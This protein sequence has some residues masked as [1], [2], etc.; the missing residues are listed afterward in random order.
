MNFIFLMDPLATVNFEKD[1]SFVFMLESYRR[2]HRVYHLAD[3]DIL[4]DRNRLSFHVTPVEPQNVREKPFI[5]HKRMTIAAETVDA[6]FVRSD[7]PFDEQYLM[8]TWLLDLLPKKVPVI[9]S[10][11]GLRTVNEKI[12]MMQFRSFIPPTFIGRRKQ[13]LLNFIREEKDVV[14]K[15]TNGYGGQ[16]V[17]HIKAGDLN[18][19]VILETLTEQ[20]SREI[21]LQKYVPQAQEGDKR[22]LLL[23][24]EPLGAV[25]RVHGPEDHRN[26]LFAG[27][28]PKATVITPRDQEVM[29]ALKPELKRLGLYFVGI[30]MIGDYLMEVNVTSPTCLQEMNRLYNQHLETK[31]IEFAE[32]LVKSAKG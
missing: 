19:N 11:L 30:D 29:A 14:T 9:N 18:T 5:E 20:W 7:P 3:G 6:V 4:L 2:G 24:G 25:L 32:G 1:T 27:G 17:M 28:Q 22:I 26:N 21:I 10:P 31:V 23:D 13:D 8:N 15:P 12:W 16:A